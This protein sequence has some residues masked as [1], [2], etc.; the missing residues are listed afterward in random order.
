MVLWS[1]FSVNGGRPF[2]TGD[3]VFSFMVSL[4]AAEDLCMLVKRWT[5]NAG[6]GD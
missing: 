4:I 3:P 5:L 6:V 1:T 2:S